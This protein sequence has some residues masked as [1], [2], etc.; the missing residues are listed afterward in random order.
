MVALPNIA[1]FLL[2]ESKFVQEVFAV[3]Q[4]NDG[5]INTEISM[6]PRPYFF[7]TISWAYNF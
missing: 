4:S 5:G 2:K 1:E 6:N 3:F 7:M